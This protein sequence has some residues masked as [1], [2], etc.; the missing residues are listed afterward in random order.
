MLRRVLSRYLP[1]RPPT[2]SEV[3]LAVL[4]LGMIGSAVT[5]RQLW[6]PAVIAGFVSFALALGP[7]ANTAVGRRVGDWFQGIGKR[8]RAVVIVLFI[9]TVAIASRTVPALMELLGDAAYGGLAAVVLYTTLHVAVTGEISGWWP[10]TAD[11][12]E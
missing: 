3:G 9:L 7:V 6:W 12:D 10:D 4:V 8:G 5:V 2:W 11:I 1:D